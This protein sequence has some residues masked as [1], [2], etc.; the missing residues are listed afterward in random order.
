M[1]TPGQVRRSG[2]TATGRRSPGSS[3]RQPPRRASSSVSD[4]AART[5]ASRCSWS[6]GQRESSTISGRVSPSARRRRSSRPAP[7]ASAAQWMRDAGVPGRYGR[8]PSTST[9]ASGS[10]TWRGSAPS[11]RRPRSR[12]VHLIG[13]VRGSTS[14]SSADPSPSRTALARSSMSRTTR[15]GGSSRR[16][17]RREN[18]ATT[19]TSALEPPTTSESG[20]LSDTGVPASGSMT[21]PPGRPSGPRRTSIIASTGSTFD[22]TVL[23]QPAVDGRAPRARPNPQRGQGPQ[24]RERDARHEQRRRIER[25]RRERED[26]PG[27]RH[28]GRTS[29]RRNALRPFNASVSSSLT[30]L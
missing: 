28:P 3:T 15:Q 25:E 6:P 8:S 21:S 14:S 16:R 13:S 18:L 5:A 1:W 9:A 17:P 12:P 7:R 30:A 22:D 20:R 19:R 4:A 23:E 2:S 10:S 26:D 24:Q 29:H 27:E 11:A